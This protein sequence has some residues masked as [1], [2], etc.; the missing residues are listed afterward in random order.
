MVKLVKLQLLV[1]K[2]SHLRLFSLNHKQK[3]IIK[4]TLLHLV[5]TINVKIISLNLF[6]IIFTFF[7]I[8]YVIVN[9]NTKVATISPTKKISAA[10]PT[11]SNILMVANTRKIGKKIEIELVK[12]SHGLGFSVTTRDN[13]A[14][15]NC[16]IYIKNVLP[17]VIYIYI[18]ILA[19]KLK[20]NK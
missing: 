4:K 2:N 6:S 7:V 16:P 14:G 19:F 11:P 8:C 15:G 20:I 13:P 5:K 9:S 1:I 12:G 18:H 3:Q 10:I 17:K